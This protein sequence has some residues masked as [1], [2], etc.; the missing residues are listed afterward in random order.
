[1]PD[2][3][4]DPDIN[5]GNEYADNQV[6]FNE[7]GDRFRGTV[8]SVEKVNTRFG[9]SIMYRLFDGANEKVMFAGSVNLKGQVLELR[10]RTGD[11][12]DVELIELRKSKAGN[13]TKIYDVQV[14]RGDKAALAPPPRAAAPQPPRAAP[15]RRPDPGRAPAPR[16]VQTADDEEDMFD[17]E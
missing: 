4:D 14:E 3:Y 9:P 5:T 13:D 6:Q 8:L 7:V 10:P 15:Q 2:I 11:V 16:T 17:D 1:M 12:L